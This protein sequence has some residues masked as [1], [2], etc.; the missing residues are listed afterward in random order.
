MPDATI[1][2]TASTFGTISGTFAADQSTVTGTVTGIV[3]GTLTGSVG[4]PGPAGAAGVGV[5]VGGTAGQFLT[6]IDGTNYNT[7]WTTVNL[8][9]YAV[10]ANNLSDLADAGTARTNLGLGSLA[11]VNDAPSNGSQYARKNAAWEVVTTTPDFIS[12]VSSPLSVTTGNLTIDLSAYLTT[13]T[14]SATY[15]T[16]SGMSS[17]LTTATAAS[18]YYLQ[19]NPS[20]FQTAANV[21]TALSPYLLSATAASTY[22][23]IAAGQPTAGT[24]GQVLTKNSGTNYDSSW[25]TLIPGDRYLTSSTTSN[26]IGNGNKTFTI[27]TGLS[28]TPT[29]NITISYDASNHMHGEVLTYNSGTGVLTVDINHHT[30]SGTYASWVV[31]VGGV[32]P[33][34][35][36]AWG[37]ITGTLSS[38]TDLQSAL[39]LKLAATTAASTYQTLAGMSSYLTTST[40][41]STYQP[42]SGM[43][44]YLTTANAATTYATILEPSVDGILTVEPNGATAATVRVNQDAN[45]YIHLRPNVCQI[46][47]ISGGVTKWF[48]NDIYLQFPGGS[49]QTVAYPGSSTFLL[50][51]DNLSGLADTAVSRT[52]LGL[53][54][55]AVETASNYLTTATAASTY[56]PISGMSTY[57]TSATAASTY[58]TIANA[59]NKA[60]LASPTFTGTPTLPT[61]TIATTQSPGN[62]TTALATTAFVLANSGS[63]SFATSTQSRAATSTTVAQSPST[64]LWQAMSPGM[65]DINRNNLSY[66]ATGTM[67]T[68]GQ[69]FLASRMTMGTA[70]AASANFRT[71]GT[72]QIDQSWALMSKGYRSYID[73]SKFTWCSGR[74]YMENAP[75]DPLVTAAFYYGKAN[76]SANG[77]LARKGFGWKLTGN[78]TAGLRNPVLQVHNGT[79]LTNVTSSFAAVAQVYWD[80]DIISLG[81]G[82]V[83][84]Y[85]NGTQVATTSAGPTG[86]TSYSG[87]SPVIWNEEFVSTGVTAGYDAVFGRGRIYV[88]P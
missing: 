65:I 29:Q 2:S 87:T 56:Q 69:G 15:Q 43:S 37:A 20:G 75:V 10:K 50:K 24:T 85:I 54:T 49:Q 57:L 1:T 18:T 79:T 16:L 28:Y 44:S 76:N 81:G 71:F 14:A 59:A 3:A 39:D 38:Q 46:A 11:V 47:V 27:G 42:L 30:G 73:F 55:M 64:S 36:V 63:T 26:T 68:S 60:D 12:S 34:T 22:A 74:F 62:N 53:G 9:V 48:F 58:F 77:D 80:W 41:A 78:A 6:K 4:V 84:L 32:T 45:N 67:G 25:A 35:S 23:V 8:S 61:G 13:A 51:A 17:Y 31:N 33:A 66:T 82:N 72:S 83:T 86:D 88:A 70:G 19:T 52:N 40:A 21:T 5:P 7:D